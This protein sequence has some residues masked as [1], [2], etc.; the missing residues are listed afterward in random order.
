MGRNRSEV[1]Y[2]LFS[3]NADVHHTISRIHARIVKR[4]NEEHLLRDDSLNGEYVNNIKINGKRF[5][6]KRC[7]VSDTSL[8]WCVVRRIYVVLLLKF[9]SGSQVL[10]EGDTVTFG[11]P[12]GQLIQC[13]A[14]VRQPDS[15]FHFL[16]SNT[17]EKNV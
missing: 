7:F 10:E 6:C 1:D 12:T 8:F 5:R 14:R 2:R 11:H 17:L 4:A 9:A 16:V 13:G 15:E 3:S